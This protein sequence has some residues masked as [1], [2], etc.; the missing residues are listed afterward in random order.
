VGVV[1]TEIRLTFDRWWVAE[2]G[3]PPS[4]AAQAARFGD[5]RR[6]WLAVDDVS[7]E[8]AISMLRFRAGLECL[9]FHDA[10][11]RPTSLEALCRT[12]PAWAASRIMHLLGQVELQ[13]EKIEELEKGRKP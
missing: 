10:A 9:N 1:S 4:D 11:G 3:H 13:R 2:V 5:C 12:E 6:F 7:S 8:D